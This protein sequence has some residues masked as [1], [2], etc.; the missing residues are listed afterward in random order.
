MDV[1]KKK[2]KKLLC[3]TFYLDSIDVVGVLKINN[4]VL[5]H[6]DLIVKFISVVAIQSKPRR[7][8]TI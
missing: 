2:K 4:N 1:F 8:N 6:F 7:V 3:F 5:L